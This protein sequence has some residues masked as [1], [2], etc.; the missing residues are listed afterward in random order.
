MQ[1]GVNPQ[2]IL[3]T[4]R[5]LLRDRSIQVAW[6]AQRQWGSE[7]APTARQPGGYIEC[8][9]WAAILRDRLGEDEVVLTFDAGTVGEQALACV[10]LAAVVL[11]MGMCTHAVAIV[12]GEGDGDGGEG[13][14][15]FWLHD[16]DSAARLRGF[17]TEMSALALNRRWGCSA[18]FYAVARRD[19]ALGRLAPAGGG[20][21]G[22]TLVRE[23]LTWSDRA[24]E[25]F[26]DRA[27]RA[28]G[29]GLM[30]LR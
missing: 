14:A 13:G 1:R 3:S 27:R 8:P 2:C 5:N 10:R 11:P 21:G 22:V 6:L 24:R 29:R 20:G 19:S 9:D 16:N 17:G 12:R 4:V 26:R 15:T 7:Q 18:K 28:A 23:A 25:A 30:D